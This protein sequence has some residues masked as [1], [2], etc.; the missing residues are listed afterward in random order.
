[1]GKSI[2]PG[3]W[4]YACTGAFIGIFATFLVPQAG[5]SN[6]S[7][8]PLS[9]I[10][11]SPELAPAPA[12]PDP[13]SWTESMRGVLRAAMGLAVQTV[14]VQPGDTLGDVLVKNRHRQSHRL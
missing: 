11:L 8:S 14:T 2:Y 3:T 7:Q 9:L 12:E 4:L 13:A 10:S 1:M 5:I 6:F